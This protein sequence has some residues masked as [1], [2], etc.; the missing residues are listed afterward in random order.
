MLIDQ[1]EITSECIPILHVGQSA[2]V[3]ASVEEVVFR[4]VVIYPNDNLRI[5]ASKSIVLSDEIILKEGAEV[6]LTIDSCKSSN[7]NC[8]DKIE[9]SPQAK[10]NAIYNFLSP[11]GDG[12][13]DTFFIEN[14]EEFS[15]VEL[16]VFSN[17]G[18]LV[19]Y[20]QSYKNDWDGG[21]ES[22]GIYRYQLRLNGGKKA[23]TGEL[24]LER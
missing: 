24:L 22:N 13:N 11:N 15:N 12:K 8:Q 4:P 2:G 20:S 3:I 23:Y 7:K 5:S 9:L 10:K 14:I 1:L 16:A 18:R 21:S 6:T 19:F 17:T